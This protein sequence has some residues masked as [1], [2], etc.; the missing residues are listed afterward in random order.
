MVLPNVNKKAPHFR[1]HTYNTKSIR[2]SKRFT[3]FE[4]VVTNFILTFWQSQ[5]LGELDEKL[6]G[7]L[8]ATLFTSG[9]IDPSVIGT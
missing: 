5:K 6:Y 4:Y 7:L 9:A 8:Q 1:L 3:E 2:T